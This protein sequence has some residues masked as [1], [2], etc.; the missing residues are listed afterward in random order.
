ML[1]SHAGPEPP[2]SALLSSPAP[3][4]PSTFWREAPASQIMVFRLNYLNVKKKKEKRT[5]EKAQKAK[6]PRG[7]TPPKGRSPPDVSGG[8]RPLNVSG[9]SPISFFF[10]SPARVAPLCSFLGICCFSILRSQVGRILRWRAV[11]RTVPPSTFWCHF[12]F[13]Y[14]LGSARGQNESC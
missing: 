5:K 14:V 1:E 12:L 4:P 2:R 13:C 9:G 10:M 6:P 7:Q 3:A 11:S 8:L